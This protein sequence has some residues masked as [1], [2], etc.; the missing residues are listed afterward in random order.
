MNL[1]PDEAVALVQRLSAE[2]AARSNYAATFENYYT[3]RH[4]LKFASP[5]FAK[6]FGALFERFSDNWCQV[7]VDAV[8]ERLTV[9]GFSLDGERELDDATW[10]LWRGQSL[11][12]DSNLAFV[13]TL[14]NGRSFGLAW[15]GPDGL[16]VT[17]EHPSQCIVAYGAGNRR[18]RVSALKVWMN[19][20]GGQDATL[21]TDT[22]VWKYTRTG[23]PLTYPTPY[24]GTADPAML[25]TA[26]NTS[27]WLP[28]DVASEPWPLP[29]TLGVVP[30]VELQNRPRLGSGPVSEIANVIPLQDSINLLWSHLLTA[31][32]FAAFAQRIV[33]GAE[34]PQVPVYDST[35]V[36]VGT[37][38][39]NLEKLRADRVLWLENP[40]AKISE[41]SAANLANYT[42]VI[43]TA[44]Q[45]LAAQTRTPPDY[46][47]GSMTNVSGDALTAAERGLVSK[48][49]ERQEYFGDGLRE[50]MR[51]AHIANGDIGA[52][53]AIALGRVRWRDAQYRTEGEHVD[54]LLKKQ[55]LGVPRDV[56]WEE[57]G[58][59]QTE[60]D[61]WNTLADE[62]TVRG[63]LAVQSAFGIP[64][65]ATID[66][67]GHPPEGEMP[68][69][70]PPAA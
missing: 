14:V 66:P 30:M 18:R 17:F 42:G 38:D 65:P 13:D 8:A 55:A 64:T 34:V 25:I 69:E 39:M 9:V 22:E 29:H 56:L 45:H 61:R 5:E 33:T 58:A 7:I 20:E 44:V 16:E 49:R 11:D 31:S 19:E 4:P 51:V 10:D 6:Q 23:A 54:A 43:E 37:K 32:D 1:T 28:R 48:V 26:A 3:G 27:G 12:V 47:L 50:L 36:K 68:N 24:P 63:D 52:A 57:L 21:Y 2:L 15:D 67:A 70:M 60:I 59:D 40:D 35:G 53:E 46:L 41:W 62:A